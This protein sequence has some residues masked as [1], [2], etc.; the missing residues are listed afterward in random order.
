MKLPCFKQ[1][2]FIEY[3][4][5]PKILCLF[6]I[7][8][9]W[10]SSSL[11][12]LLCIPITKIWPYTHYFSHQS[13]GAEKDGLDIVQHDWAMPKFEQR[14]E[15]VLR[16]LVSWTSDVLAFVWLDQVPFWCSFVLA[17]Q[18]H[19]VQKTSF[20]TVT[21]ESLMLVEALTHVSEI[22]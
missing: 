6:H 15:A 1:S 21:V 9:C 17:P 14:A 10:L 22:F 11:H 16:K 8:I 2:M 13:L 12:Y 18:I 4:G 5:Q 7:C 3:R 19:H 20:S